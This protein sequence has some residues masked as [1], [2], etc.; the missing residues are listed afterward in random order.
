MIRRGT[1]ALLASLLAVPAVLLAGTQ[2]AGATVPGFNG[3]IVFQSN[4]DGNA[5]IYAVGPGLVG[6]VNLTNNAAGDTAPVWSPDGSK[7][8]FISNRNP[9][10]IYVM[11]ADGS[12]PH[13]VTSPTSLMS[14]GLA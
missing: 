12:S 14:S 3:K 13:F 11:N 4:R 10:G 9:G 7:I 2:P 1:V 6:A 5:E 8:A